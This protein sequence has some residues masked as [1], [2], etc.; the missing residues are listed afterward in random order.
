MVLAAQGV[1]GGLRE[2]RLGLAWVVTAR[3]SQIQL[4]LQWTHHETHLSPLAKLVAILAKRLSRK[5]RKHH[6]GR[7]GGKKESE[8][9]QREQRGGWWRK[10]VFPQSFN[11]CYLPLVLLRQTQVSS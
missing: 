10:G 6:R 7:G 1:Q 8:K 9:H 4:V 5:G 3:H 2:D 11:V